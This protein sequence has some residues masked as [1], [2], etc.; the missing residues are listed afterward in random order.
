MWLERILIIV[1]TLSRDFLPSR[2]GFYVPTIWDWLLLAGT[3]GFFC[4]LFF[5]FVRLLPIVSMHEL[6]QLAHEE[7]EG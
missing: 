4:F 7:R 3:L 2:W 6:R 5:C 1:N